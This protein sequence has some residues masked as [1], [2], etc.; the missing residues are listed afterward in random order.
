MDLVTLQLKM[1]NKFLSV[2]QV[3]LKQPYNDAGTVGSK[4]GVKRH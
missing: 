3:T 2:E 1:H 4:A